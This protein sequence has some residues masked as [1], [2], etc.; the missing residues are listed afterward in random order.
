SP[1]GELKRQLDIEPLIKLKR[2]NTYALYSMIDGNEVFRNGIFRI[3][4]T[5]IIEHIECGIIK[6]VQNANGK[7]TIAINVQE[8]YQSHPWHASIN[9]DHLPSVNIANP[10]IQ[11][12]FN[13]WKYKIIDGNHRMD[14]AYRKG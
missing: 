2:D 3:N 9:E 11:V 8:W 1:R 10:V 12:E 4:I 13:P 6:P 14:L 7:N 5:K